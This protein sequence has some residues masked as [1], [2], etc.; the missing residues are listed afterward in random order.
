MKIQI[1]GNIGEYY[2]QTLCMLFFPGVKFSKNESEDCSLSAVV[3]VE[4]TSDI[5]SATVVLTDENK[6]ATGTAS[7]KMKENAKV[8]AEQIACGKAFFEAGKKLT[9]LTPSWGIL[10]GVRPAKLAISDL[11]NGK[12]KTEVRNALTKEYLVTPKKASLVT[13]IAAVEKKL[14]ARVKPTSCSLYVS[15]PFCPSRCSYCS[16]VSF[17]SAKLLGLLDSYLERLCHDINETID[18][19]NEL[20]LQI[21]TVYIG[22]G[23]PTTLNEKQ[24]QILLDTITARISPETL[25]EFT[26][27]A[28]RPDTIT[29]EKLHIIREH[30]VTRVSINTQTLND[31]VLE[32]VGRKHTSADFYRAFEMARNENIKIINTDLIAGLP[33]EGFGS[34]SDT[35]DRIVELRPENLT[36]HTLCIKNAADFAQQKGHMKSM[37][38][39]SETSKCVDYSQISAKNAGYIPYYIYRQKNTVNN[40]ENVGFA[41]PGTEGLYNIYMMEEIQTIFAVGAGAVSKMVSRDGKSI[42]RIFE[43]K[44]PYE[45]LADPDGVKNKE[46][47]EKSINFYH[48]IW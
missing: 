46:K 22:G 41:L 9:G 37:H 11:K 40:L 19:I 34:F 32:L 31:D 35:I 15:I 28:G 5:V 45:Y 17:T 38:M 10:T 23:T 44:Y 36:F 4:S 29:Q 25:E 39:Y 20:G 1:S 3:S 14:I 18:T 48:D 12:T 6:T 42:E 27:E 2:V 47:R 24:L 26:V 8:S 30:G 33:G 21:T 16:F 13:E 43:Y 7:E